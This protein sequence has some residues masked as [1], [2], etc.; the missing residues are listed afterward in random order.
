MVT[1]CCPGVQVSRS[2]RMSMLGLLMDLCPAGNTIHCYL[3]G[4]GPWHR[5]DSSL[6]QR[7]N[8][9]LWKAPCY[10]MLVRESP[11]HTR[12]AAVFP[13]V[14]A[15]PGSEQPALRARPEARRRPPRPGPPPSGP[16]RPRL[17]RAP[18]PRREG[19]R[20]VGAAHGDGPGAM[21]E[22]C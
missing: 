7:S 18:A 15:G 19:G 1:E 5:T 13:P 9:A 6:T 21:L 10:G 4:D 12:F 22:G 11:P 16:A 14:C 8:A 2:A 20:A 17:P 3:T